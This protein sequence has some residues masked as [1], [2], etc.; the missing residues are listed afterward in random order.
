[1]AFLAT[2]E[3]NSV[4]L[5]IG[6]SNFRASN[7]FHVQNAL[8]GD[9]GVLESLGGVFLSWWTDDLR[10]AISSDCFLSS[11]V[12]TDVSVFGGAQWSQ[13]YGPTEHVGL[14][15]N[16]TMSFN[17]SMVI[18][19]QSARIGKSFRGRVYQAGLIE[20]DADAGVWN[21]D[22]LTAMQTSYADLL[23]T[24]QTNGTPLAILS[25]QTGGVARTEGLLTLV[26]TVRANAKVD[27]QR[28][29]TNPVS[30]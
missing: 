23:S 8:P 6:S 26:R 19:L 4:V 16:P 28:R 14:V 15:A 27:S 11:I 2:P 24:L 25:R 20:G 21:S 7:V 12:V 17:S 18:T 3:C 30:T 9:T 10:L 22:A 1:M 13:T 5:T 29:R